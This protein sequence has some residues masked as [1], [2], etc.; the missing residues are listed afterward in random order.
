MRVRIWA[1]ALAVNLSLG[2]LAAAAEHER[3]KGPSLEEP[4]RRLMEASRGGLSG[5]GF[6]G[7]PEW[8]VRESHTAQ[9]LYAVWSLPGAAVAVGAGGT[10]LRS[11]DRGSHW[12]PVAS[13]TREDLRGIVG[14][15]KNELFVVGSAGTLLHSGDQGATWQALATGTTAPLNA[16]ASDG[17]SLFAVGA[18]G[19]LLR[20]TD[21]GGTWTAQSSSVSANLE[22]VTCPHPGEVWVVGRGH[23]ALHSTDGGTTFQQ[24]DVGGRSEDL[25]LVWSGPRGDLFIAGMQGSLL[26]AQDG[27]ATWVAMENPSRMPVLAMAS[28]DDGLFAAGTGGAI[29]HS[30]NGGARWRGHRSDTVA[31]LLGLSAGPGGGLYAVGTGGTILTFP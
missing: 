9:N 31:S 12:A 18:G 6:L 17:R 21:A 5:G 4:G 8:D 22:G 11:T 26:H 16:I 2:G 25:H 30:M 19:T 24:V 10:V 3:M 27:G 28:N 20:S 29:Q 7:P 13:P 15:G 14:V 1:A 23:T